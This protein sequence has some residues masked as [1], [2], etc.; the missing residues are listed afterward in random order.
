MKY[1]NEILASFAKLGFTPRI[2]QVEC[3]DKIL[4]EFVDNNKTDVC[5]VAPTGSGKS[6]IGIVVPETLRTITNYSEHLLSVVGMHQNSLVEQY[7]NTFKAHDS[8]IQVKGANNYS[9]D[10]LNSTADNCTLSTI[11]S[12]PNGTSLKEKHCNRCEYNKLKKLRNKTEHLITNYSFIFIDRMQ[13]GI[14]DARLCYVWDE[15]HLLN[16]VFSDHNAVHVSVKRLKEFIVDVSNT[17]I[18]AKITLELIK[19][20]AQL[21]GNKVTDTN[22]TKFITTLVELYL[23]AKTY[24]EEQTESCIERGDFHLFKKYSTLSK[25]YGNLYSKIADLLRYNYTCV[26]DA[27]NDYKEFVIKAVFIGEMFNALRNSKYNLFM[28]ATLTEEYIRTTMALNAKTTAFIKLESL[29]QKENKEVLFVKPLLTLNYQS[30]QKK[31]TIDAMTLAVNS[32]V[33]HHEEKNES[34]II[35]VPSFNVCEFIAA[36]LR[37]HIKAIKIF[38]HKRGEKAADIVNAFKK[39]AGNSVLISPSIFEGIDLPDDV[40]RFQIITKVPFPSL[41]DKRIKYILDNYPKVYQAV[42]LHK[43]VQCLGRSVRSETDHA[44][45]YVLDQHG[46]NLLTS[47]E[48]IWFNEVVFDF[49][50]L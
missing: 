6:I 15:A 16:D 17:L 19:L 12:I 46:Y 3:C 14:L 40:S 27:N 10:V 33:K 47:A 8:V 45:T 11:H 28:S 21:D 13:A 50:E 2:G 25:K 24:F 31:T 5:L 42:T 34:G 9:C 26:F 22:Y 4:V 18:A 30:M 23:T 49:I 37:K 7:S 41:A 44:V 35:F 39:Y 36:S 38:E 32:I 29:F 1:E 20:I 43:V 48:N